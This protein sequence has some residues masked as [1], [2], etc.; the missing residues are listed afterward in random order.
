MRNMFNSK[1][2]YSCG[3][4]KCLNNPNLNLNLNLNLKTLPL[5]LTWWLLSHSESDSESESECENFAST[6][7][8]VVI[9]AFKI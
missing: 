3:S 4:N 9:I 7:D 2:V 6:P 1:T 5:R 8:K